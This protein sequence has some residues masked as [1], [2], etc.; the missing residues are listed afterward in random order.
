MGHSLADVDLPYFKEIV[1]RIDGGNVSWKISYYD[2]DNLL[3]LRRQFDKLAGA[4]GAS[5]EFAQLADF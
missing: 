4:F 2:G 3:R 5:V 1:Q